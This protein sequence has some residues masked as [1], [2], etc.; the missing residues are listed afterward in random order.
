VGEDLTLKQFLDN[1]D[2]CDISTEVSLFNLLEAQSS[3]GT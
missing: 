1:I 3:F 2:R